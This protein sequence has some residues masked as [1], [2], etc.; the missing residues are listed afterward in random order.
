MSRMDQAEKKRKLL[1]GG[2]L[3]ATLIA[4]V[5]VEEEEPVVESVQTVQPTNSLSEKG[6]RGELGKVRVEENSSEYLDVTKLGQRKFSAQAGELFNSITWVAKKPRINMQQQAA[7]LANQTAKRSA[8]PPTPPPLE[9]KYIGKVIEGN[10]TR[11]FLSQYDQFHVV[12]L[13]GRID[14]QYRVDAVDDEAITLTYLPL[15]AKQTLNINN[16]SSGNIR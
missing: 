9:F 3:I 6:R 2:A 13:G 5:L 7:F 15:N 4:V 8:P 12:K 14:N 1:L 10:K 16:E 11:V